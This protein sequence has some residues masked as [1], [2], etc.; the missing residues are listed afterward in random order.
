MPQYA[1]EAILIRGLAKLQDIDRR[2]LYLATVV[3][4]LASFGVRIPTPPGQTSRATRGLFDAIES[5]PPDKVVL[6]DSS[7]NQGSQA[8]NLAQLE[9][10]V[11]H[12][13]R[14]HTRFVVTSVGVTFFGPE[15]ARR[16]IEPIAA[17]AGYEYG[18]DWVNC[19]YVQAGED[20]K[21]IIDGLCR[22]FHR[23]YPNDVTGQ[24]MTDL[25]LMSKVRS[26]RDVHLVYCVTYS[27]SEDWISFVKGQFGTPV[28]FGCMTIMSPL[29]ATYIDSGQLCGMLA[30]NRGAAEYE[31][32]L[33]YEGTA[34]QGIT[35]AS[36][37][38]CMIL[39]A[40]V[41]GNLGW[42]AARRLREHGNMHRGA[43]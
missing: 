11:R 25:P 36:F 26:I 33:G 8:E 38:N 27:P 41:L 10:V 7:W 39:A 19:G 4:L 9:C 22:D 34:T 40:V 14:R 43:R 32:L 12:L 5:C 37:G 28:A 13:C 3:V 31:A 18:V 20:Y 42:W 17:D 2:W 29:Y 30:G 35:F 6:I 1:K 23:I 21:V 16:F 24:P 15:F